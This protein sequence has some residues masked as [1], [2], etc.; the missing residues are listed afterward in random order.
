[1]T[2][3]E[4]LTSKSIVAFIGDIF[5]RRAADSYL[6]EPVTIREHM[7]QAAA[8]AEEAGASDDVIAAALLHDIGHFTHEFP[9]DAQDGIDTHHDAAGAAVLAPFFPQLVTDCVR[10]HVAAKRYLCATDPTY[11]DRLSPA[12]VHSLK[13]QGG[14]MTPP[15]VRAFRE[16]PNLGPI[17]QVRIWDEEA[18]IPGEPTPPFAHYAPMLQR[19]VDTDARGESNR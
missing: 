10:H 18:K 8:L 9:E 14:P 12:S 4:Q 16:N 6:G 7:L 19:V 3:P 2:R 5:E 15:E 17:L 1:M 11:F 13:L